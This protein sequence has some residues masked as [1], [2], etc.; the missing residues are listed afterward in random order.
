M[1]KKDRQCDDMMDKKEIDESKYKSFNY[2]QFRETD[3][4]NLSTLE[5]KLVLDTYK[6]VSGKG[7]QRD[8]RMEERK[9]DQTTK[10]FNNTYGHGGFE[11]DES[12][13]RQGE[14]TGFRKRVSS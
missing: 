1:S 2:V 10:S 11:R 13:C 6:V 9:M 8:D 12:Q 14:L 4:E 7:K 3:R 5:R